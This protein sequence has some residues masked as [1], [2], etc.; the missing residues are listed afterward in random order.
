MTKLKN[1]QLI[2]PLASVPSKIHALS[3]LVSE[4][5]VRV[6]LI[7]I[8]GEYHDNYSNIPPYEKPFL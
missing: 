4:R 6:F 7:L 1:I 5:T 3:R 8:T 2:S